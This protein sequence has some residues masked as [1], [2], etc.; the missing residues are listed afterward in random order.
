[1]FRDAFGIQI[2]VVSLVAGSESADYM[3]PYL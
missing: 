3:P 2:I 1:M